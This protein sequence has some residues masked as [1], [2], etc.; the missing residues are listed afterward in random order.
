MNEPAGGERARLAQTL[1]RFGRCDRPV[2]ASG[3]TVGAVGWV[4]SKGRQVGLRAETA[5]E[6]GGDRRVLAAVL[7]KSS[8]VGTAGHRRSAGK[9]SATS[10]P[11]GD[12]G[13]EVSILTAT[14]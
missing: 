9:F 14:R 7:A 3:R 12:D 13:H 5:I 2:W 6:G 1:W 11:G 10:R 4:V 8:S